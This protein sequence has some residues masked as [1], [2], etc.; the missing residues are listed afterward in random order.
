MRRGDIVWVDLEP[1]IGSEADK[2]RPA[3]VASNDGANRAAEQRGRGVV[4][5]VPVTTNTERVH[6]FQVLLPARRC[7]LARTS[8]AQAEQ[9]RS[10]SIERVGEVAG[11]CA[12]WAK[13]GDSFYSGLAWRLTGVPDSLRGELGVAARGY[14]R[15]GRARRL[16]RPRADAAGQGEGCRG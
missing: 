9:I 14:G 11:Q 6:P 5:V 1:V 3:V 8:K 7:G 12:A 4:T 2:R 10:V 16:P 15:H 13:P